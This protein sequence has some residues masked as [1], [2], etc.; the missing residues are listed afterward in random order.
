MRPYMPRA[1]IGARVMRNTVRKGQSK[2]SQ[3]MDPQ[4]LP[5]RHFTKTSVVLRMVAIFEMTK[6]A[7]TL[8]LG[9]ELFHLMHKNLD[10]VAER[11][12]HVLH[13]DPEGKVSNHVLQPA[14]QS[15]DR[16]L[17]VLA[18]GALACAY[19]RL[20]EGYG[21]WREREWAEWFSLLSTALHLPRSCTGCWIIR[22][23]SGVLCLSPTL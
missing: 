11:L 13:F 20:A 2:A 8:L 22:V 23:G 10:E 9:C 1:S 19:V 21:L 16:N 3:I 12:I 6:A 15:S 14:S 5:R 17:R 7:I 4:A 18:L